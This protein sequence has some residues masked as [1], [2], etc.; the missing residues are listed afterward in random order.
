MRL[1]YLHYGPQSG[2]TPSVAR[3]LS[4]AGVEV[5]HANPMERFLWR[6]RPGWP[7][8]N[9]RP[10]P[11]RAFVESLR[12]NGRHWKSFWCHTT[13]AFDHMS[14]LAGEAI[15]RAR[16]DAVLQAGAL[17]SPGRF[18]EVPYH[19]YLDHT[20][21]IAERYD[22]LPGLDPPMPRDAA[23][24]AREQA[25][26]RG[27]A[28][29]FTM[30]EFVK[31]SLVRDY[32]VDPARVHVVG[33]GPNVEPRTG[34]PA[35][36]REKAILFVGRNFVPKGGPQ[37]VQAYRRVRIAQPDARLWIVSE[38]A[39]ADLP[40]GA[41]HLG[42]LGPE[43]LAALY[44]RASVFALPTL[45]E[46]FGLAFVE[47]MTF[48]LPIVA[49]RLEAIP[50]IVSDGETGVLVPPGDTDALAK[51]LGD[52]LADPVRA[53]LMGAAGRARVAD[54]FGWDRAVARMLAVMRPARLAV[55][56]PLPA[57]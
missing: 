9:V 52:L 39:P 55:A 50:E 27:A 30:S 43:R 23:W 31:G 56:A 37:L 13:Y 20:R 54:R 6:L 32:G 21:A 4:A 22:R 48:G 42:L 1:L 11:V 35:A 7:I 40:L 24:R 45:R 38:T 34:E 51:A 14:T 5:L 41:E 57:S 47:A 10:A 8:P 3:A 28:G 33:A 16:P 25:V 36:A 12:A 18:P 46:A 29:I 19:L 17:F 26:Y 49:P 15:R 53:R 2:V 44:G